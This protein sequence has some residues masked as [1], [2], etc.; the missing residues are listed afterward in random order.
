M[1]PTLMRARDCLVRVRTLKTFANVGGRDFSVTLNFV[2]WWLQD[3][4]QGA[5]AAADAIF[6]LKSLDW[7][8]VSEDVA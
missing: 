8:C 2:P 4:A 1:S 3:V 7:V 5:L 6:S